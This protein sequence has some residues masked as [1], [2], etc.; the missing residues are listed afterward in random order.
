MNLSLLPTEG[1]GFAG[2]LPVSGVSIDPACPVLSVE[3]M[4]VGTDTVDL[5]LDASLHVAAGETLCLVGESGC[6]KSLT[7]LAAM[8]LLADPVRLKAGRISLLGK[9][10]TGLDER[11]LRQMRGR[12]MAMIFQDP[13]ASLNPVQ[14]V[15]RQV[16]EALVVHDGV[17]WKAAM[18]RAVE[19]LDKVGIHDPEKRA[20]AYPHQ[21]S[22][23]MCQRVM[24]AMALA[25][26]PRL[27]VSDE[28]T[29]ALDV[30]TQAQILKLMK[31]LQNETGTAMIFVTH[32]LSVVAEIADRVAVMY[33]GRIVETGT[34]D[35][36]FD[37][38][39]HPY[40]QGLMNCRLHA[41]SAAA[42]GQLAA[43]G[44]TVPRPAARPSGCA[45]RQRCERQ[46]DRCATW[47]APRSYAGSQTVACHFPGQP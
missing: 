31:T 42:D 44:G 41:L 8:G 16:A 12:D 45:F 40:T 5:V 47:P 13:G 9:D 7:C 24:I 21:L 11:S 25:C 19:L 28:A 30:T 15:G 27:I 18:R 10:L 36:I 20:V 39:A 43:I 6:G 14:R 4:T 32:D 34:V 37:H 17:S 23:G 3:A 2:A 33:S 26:R 46:V 29:T 35:D 22:G 38:P 1:A